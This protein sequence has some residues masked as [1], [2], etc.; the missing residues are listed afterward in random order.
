MLRGYEFCIITVNLLTDLFLRE[1]S[2]YTELN[3]VTGGF[4]LFG[5]LQVNDCV[6]TWYVTHILLRSLEEHRVFR[7]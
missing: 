5:S 3:A 1:D 7:W 6:N 2:Q 4:K